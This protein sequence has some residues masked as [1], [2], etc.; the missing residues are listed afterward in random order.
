MTVGNCTLGAVK[1]VSTINLAPLFAHGTEPFSWS[2]ETTTTT[3]TTAT[4]NPASSSASHKK[5]RRKTTLKN[6]TS[7][8]PWVAATKTTSRRTTT[9]TREL[10]SLLLEQLLPETTTRTQVDKLFSH[11]QLEGRKRK[12]YP[13]EDSNG[14]CEYYYVS[15]S[16]SSSDGPTGKF[17][18]KC[19]ERLIQAVT[20]QGKE[21]VLITAGKTTT[22][23]DLTVNYATDAH[24]PISPY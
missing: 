20:E 5:I 2:K 3:K 23:D 10:H 15:Y 9:K 4:T 16:S 22:A 1:C 14:N 17:S 18:K 6:K 7:W 13:L 12:L 8:A 11:N 21:R 24:C 19:P